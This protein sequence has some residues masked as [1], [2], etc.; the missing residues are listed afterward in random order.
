M[1]PT[2]KRWSSSVRL[3]RS[4]RAKPSSPP[5]KHRSTAALRMMTFT[6]SMA[7][8]KSVP[9]AGHKVERRL[10]R[11]RDRLVRFR[12]AV[13][14]ELPGVAH[15]ADQVEVEVGDYDV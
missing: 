1:K 8:A 14:V 2:R 11:R 9:P 4:W 7:T 13:A 15:L 10:L 12:P 3:F 6:N 5:G